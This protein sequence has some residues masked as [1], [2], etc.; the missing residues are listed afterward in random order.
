M[1]THL[2]AS[3]PEGAKYEA[4]L[5]IPSLR[6]VKP[7]WLD[8]C[9][10]KQ[11]WISTKDFRMDAPRDDEN[12]HGVA[13]VVE[14]ILPKIEQQLLA[15]RDDSQLFLDCHVF[16]VGFDVDEDEPQVKAKLSRL[17]RRAMGTIHWTVNETLT[18]IIIADGL[19]EQVR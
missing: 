5:S 19:E 1:N 7:E 15:E 9:A 17:L 4:A 2:I 10:R 14:P 18:H 11:K 6:I 12:E 3:A 13:N 16:L 8:A